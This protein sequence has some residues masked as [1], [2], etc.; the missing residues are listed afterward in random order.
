MAMSSNS[1]VSKLVFA[2]VAL[3]LGIALAT[4]AATMTLEV[5]EKSIAS[6]ETY[7]LNTLGCYTADGEV[8][9]S[10]S[11]CNITVTYAPTSWKIEDCPLTSV[12]VA[13]ATGT[14]LTDDTDYILE[15]T[16]GLVAFLNTTDTATAGLGNTS[17]ITYTYCGDDYMNL[18]WGRTSMKTAVGFFALALLLVAI[19]LFWSVAK[20]A[21]LLN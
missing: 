11:A 15:E 18:N 10:A 12:T 9:E 3:I 20:D 7:D 4:T 2:F 13:N 8:N 1:S 21:G 14:A 17:L 19:A 16:T 6:E 5:T